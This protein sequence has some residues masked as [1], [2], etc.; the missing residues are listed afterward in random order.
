MFFE[1]YYPSTCSLRTLD[2]QLLPDEVNDFANPCVVLETFL[3]RPIKVQ[4]SSCILK[5]KW[6][7]TSWF[8]YADGSYI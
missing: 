1:D 8:T 3:Y 4:V 5:T 7:T 2:L 6:T